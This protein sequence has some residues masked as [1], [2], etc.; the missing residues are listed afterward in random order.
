MHTSLS[1]SGL[2]LGRILLSGI[3]LMSAVMKATHWSHTEETMVEKGMVAVP[4]FLLMAILFELCGGLS[5]LLGF[6]ARW[7]ALLLILFLIPVTLVFHNFW[8]YEG[9]MMENQ[10]QHFM[11]NL[12]ILGGLTTL[13]AAGAGA[14]SLDAWLARRKSQAVGIEHAPVRPAMA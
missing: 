2:L 12:T 1:S 5:V 13:A 7:G 10:M 3:F 6:F 11:K 4:F 9:K 14:Y 8:A